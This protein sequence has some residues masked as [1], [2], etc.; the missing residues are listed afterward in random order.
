M[1]LLLTFCLLALS[2]LAQGP[3]T[4]VTTTLF[5]AP[6]DGVV[7]DL[8]PEELSIRTKSGLT[9]KIRAL[10]FTGSKPLHLI[11]MVDD[12]GST[13]YSQA[14]ET[15]LENI[16]TYLPN[17]MSGSDKAM[18]ISFNDKPY[19]VCQFTQDAK[20][21]KKALVVHLAKGGTLF[22]DSLASVMVDNISG[23]PGKDRVIVVVLT[24]GNDNASKTK[25]LDVEKAAVE[26]HVPIFAI[27]LSQ[28][29]EGKGRKALKALAQATGGDVIELVTDSP[30]KREFRRL[31]DI[32]GSQYLVSIE[33]PPKSQ[34]EQWQVTINRPKTR[35][36][37]PSAAFRQ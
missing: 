1:K 14:K 11:F 10:E 21:I 28:F 9:G 37:Y 16:G 2:A 24:D 25:Q 20:E 18:V 36:L 26:L 32:F 4:T 15:A 33:L 7:Q 29:D 6:K 30:N 12:S 23:L 31:S 27:D 22:L 35:V 5:I 19:L 17:L 8:K 34:D 3:T 13:R